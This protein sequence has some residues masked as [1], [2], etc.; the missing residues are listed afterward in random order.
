M[1]EKSNPVTQSRCVL[2]DHEKSVAY[3]VFQIKSMTSIMNVS[4]NVLIYKLNDLGMKTERSN[5]IGTF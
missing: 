1:S 5:P 3:G 4:Q 2:Q